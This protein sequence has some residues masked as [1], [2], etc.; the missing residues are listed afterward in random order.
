MF[1]LSKR[2]ISIF[3]SS[4]A[5]INLFKE[6][7]GLIFYYSI[8]FHSSEKFQLFNFLNSI[9]A[10]DHI[11]SAVCSVEIPLS[12]AKFW[13]ISGILS[14]VLGNSP[15]LDTGGIYGL[16]VSVSRLARLHVAI[17]RLAFLLPE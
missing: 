10:F 8:Y 3:T 4:S 7:I 5:C 14:G 9:C 17:A 11:A 2:F 16:S 13:A 12:K 6:I 1:K 15:A